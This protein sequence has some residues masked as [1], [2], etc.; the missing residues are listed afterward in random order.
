MSNARNAILL[1]AQRKT[2]AYTFLGQEVE[3][4]ELSRIEVMQNY[5]DH[6]NEDGKIVGLQAQRWNAAIACLGTYD[7]ESGERIF[8]SAD[9]IMSLPNNEAIW[10]QI[11]EMVT[12]INALSEVGPESLKSSDH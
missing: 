4:R 3:L 6:A 9:E 2:R 7:P 11:T 12:I 5:A 8:V 10:S 1:A